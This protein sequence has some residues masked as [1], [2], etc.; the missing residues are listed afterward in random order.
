MTM[1]IGLKNAGDTYQW[2][3]QGCLSEQISHN[4]EAYVNDVVVKNKYLATLINDLEG[5]FKNL[6]EWQWKLNPNKVAFSVPSGQLLGFLVSHRGIEDSMK[7]IHTITEMGP[8]HCVKDVKKVTRC[9]AA[10]NHF[11]SRLGE[12]GLSFFKFLKKL[13][14]FKWLEEANKAFEKLKAYLIS[15]PVLT[16]LTLHSSYRH[17]G[18]CGDHSRKGQRRP[19]I[20]CTVACLLH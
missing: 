12:K 17:G 19:C 7:Q 20:Q 10:H 5:T 16:P 11:I 15:S 18:Q 8:P 1:S 6:R 2:A 9:M 13:G 4:I 14:K 3:I